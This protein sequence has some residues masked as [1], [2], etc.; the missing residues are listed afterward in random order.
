MVTLVDHRWAGSTRGWGCTFLAPFLIVYCLVGLNS[1]EMSE[2]RGQN[3]RTLSV[4]W[5]PASLTM[6]PPP[7]P[8]PAPQTVAVAP[9]P[10]SSGAGPGPPSL[11]IPVPVPTSSFIS[12]PLKGSLQHMGHGDP[13]PERGWGTP[14]SLDESVIPR[15]SEPTKHTCHSF[16]WHLYS[17]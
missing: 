2:W 1:L 8:A 7:A 4:G 9:P 3:Q 15:L 11:P 6:P 16:L 5:F 13:H 10:S 14:E 17:P 12:T